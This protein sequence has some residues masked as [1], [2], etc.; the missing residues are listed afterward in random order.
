MAV[1][2]L[3]LV[4][5]FSKVSRRS[6][7]GSGMVEAQTFSRNKAVKEAKLSMLGASRTRRS[8]RSAHP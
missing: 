2:A 8:P 1:A 7:M 5:E 4:V 3:D 6:K